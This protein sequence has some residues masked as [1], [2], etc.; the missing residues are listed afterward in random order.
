M[1]SQKTTSPEEDINL[2][3]VIENIGQIGRAR[4]QSACQSIDNKTFRCLWN[5]EVCS[6]SE[7]LKILDIRSHCEKKKNL[8]TEK[9]RV[10]M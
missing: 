2:S 5:N 4:L 8:S 6:D 10:I 1:K 3:Q 7:T 9:K